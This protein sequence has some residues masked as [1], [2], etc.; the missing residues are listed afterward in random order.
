MDIYTVS[1]LIEALKQCPPDY[2]VMIKAEDGFHFLVQLG[3]DPTE[4]TVDLFPD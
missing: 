1:E 4:K 3:I 2:P